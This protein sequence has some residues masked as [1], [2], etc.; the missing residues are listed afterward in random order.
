MENEWGE[1][2]FLEKIIWYRLIPHQQ[3]NQNLIVKIVGLVLNVSILE[4]E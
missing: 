2:K 1:L 3:I 4:R